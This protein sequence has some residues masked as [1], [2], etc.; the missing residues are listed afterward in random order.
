MSEVSQN[1]D[2]LGRHSFLAKNSKKTNGK[3]KSGLDIIIR[4]IVLDFSEEKTLKSQL[5]VIL[6]YH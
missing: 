5:Q 6:I 3:E 1:E 2:N 4:I